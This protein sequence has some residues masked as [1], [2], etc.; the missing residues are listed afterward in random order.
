MPLRKP[1][2]ALALAGRYARGSQEVPAKASR[3]TPP[4]QHL[5]QKAGEH[6]RVGGF[7]YAFYYLNGVMSTGSPTLMNLR[8]N[9]WE[10]CHGTEA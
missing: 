6:D 7:G 8:A 3:Q 5:Q 1:D 10:R 9:A 4:I 2:R